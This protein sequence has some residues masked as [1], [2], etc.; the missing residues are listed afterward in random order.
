VL[1]FVLEIVTL[2]RTV[3]LADILLMYTLLLL[4][5]GP[6]ILL[7]SQGY[8]VIVLAGSWLVWGLWQFAPQ[9]SSVL[10]EIHGNEVFNLSP[11]Q[12]L[13]VT[14]IAIGWHRRQIEA[15][16]ARTPRGVRGVAILLAGLAV[17]AL[18]IAQLTQLEVLQANGLL[19][20]F[21]FDKP[22][23]VI[24]PARGT[25]ALAIVS[26]TVATWVWVPI[27]RA[28]GWL[29]L[30]LGQHAL[31]AYSLHIFVVALAAKLSMTCSPNFPA[32]SSR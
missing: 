19:E 30:P 26:F 29:L 11:W 28:T 15:W 14:G 3:Y 24:R 25:G 27:N 20:S 21:A 17:P 10:W 8:T 31:A 23:L 6:V 2:H 13:F 16:L 9:S 4:M 7:L 18:Y 22:D 12:V 5:A 32:G 1:R